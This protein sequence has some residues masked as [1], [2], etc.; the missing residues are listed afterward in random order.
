MSS[1]EDLPHFCDTQADN[2]DDVAVGESVSILSHF[3]LTQ[4]L[5]YGRAPFIKSISS[6]ASGNQTSVESVAFLAFQLV[7]CALR[8]YPEITLPLTH[9]CCS[10]VNHILLSRFF[11]VEDNPPL[12]WTG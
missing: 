4:V 8:S 11:I 9:P 6:G 12:D 5:P 2:D 1:E 7:S 3:Y 10:M